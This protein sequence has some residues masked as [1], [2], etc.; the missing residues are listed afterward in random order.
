IP[1]VIFFPPI[2]I[3]RALNTGT[4]I[5]QGD[6]FYSAGLHRNHVLATTN[7]GE[8]GRG[9]GKNAGEW[10]GKVEISKEEIPGSKRS[11]YVY[12]LTYSRL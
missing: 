11:T 3:P 7:T 8:I 5:T 6:L 9:F 1:Q 12:I 4:C 10:T 2:Y